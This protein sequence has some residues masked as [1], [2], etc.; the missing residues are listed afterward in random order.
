MK[1]RFVKF[2]SLTLAGSMALSMPVSAYSIDAN[3]NSIEEIEYQEGANP[4]F[5]NET[6][7]LAEIGSIYKVTI[8][9]VIVL[10]GINKKAGYYVNVEGDLAPYETVYVVPEETVDLYSNNKSVQTGIITQDKVTWTYSTLNTKTNGLVTADGISAGKWSGIFYFNLRLD[11][12]LGD[13][14]NP[15]HECTP[16]NFVVEN[17]IEPTCT[18]F[19]S[20]DEVAYCT[21]CKKELSRITKSINTYAHDFQYN[22]KYTF[23]EMQQIA[24]NGAAAQYDIKIG[25]TIDLFKTCTKCGLAEGTIKAQVVEIGDDYIEFATM[26]KVV[27]TDPNAKRIVTFSGHNYEVGKA[28]LFTEPQLNKTIGY[29]GSNLQASVHA[30]FDE[31]PDEFKSVLKSV[32]KSYET[33]TLTYTSGRYYWSVG[34][35]SNVIENVYIPSKSDLESGKFVNNDAY[36]NSAFWISSPCP[37]PVAYG[38]SP[39]NAFGAFYYGANG[40]VVAGYTC[41]DDGLGAIVMFKIG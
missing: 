17:M 36:I 33:A 4:D 12:V 35:K 26:S 7:V 16:G 15:N 2:L 11:K 9:K 34:G 40:R 37:Y 23:E 24:K 10:S 29:N 1:N 5:S 21:D 39:D 41:W 14:I 3:G 22:N 19:G 31:Q 25:D 20:Y 27:G 30:W 8:P 6:S 32:D 13:V 18:T 38:T 28:S